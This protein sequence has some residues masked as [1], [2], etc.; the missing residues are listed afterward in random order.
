LIKPLK[1][2]PSCEV[3]FSRDGALLAT[4]GRYVW[5]WELARRRKIVRAHPFPHPSHFDF[6]PDKSGLAVK[7]TSGR[8]GVIS[9]QSG[10]TVVDFNNKKDGERSNLLYSFCGEATLR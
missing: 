3:A 7:N 2:G 8:I 4:L 9:A 1:I 10:E 6:S 5:V